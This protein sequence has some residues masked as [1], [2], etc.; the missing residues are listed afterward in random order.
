[1]GKND[2]P[3]GRVSGA[4][5]QGMFAE[6]GGKFSLSGGQPRM[7]EVEHPVSV[8]G[9]ALVGR[10]DIGQYSY[11]GR[12][13]EIRNCIFGRFCS[14]ARRVCI[15]LAE[16]PL[17][18]LTSHPIAHGQP[19]GF[20]NDPYIMRLMPSA[21]S[22]VKYR[23]SVEVGHDVWIGDGAFVRQG[24]RIGTGAVVAARAVVTRDVPPY[25]I[26]SGLPAR[27]Q[28]Y[29]FSEETIRRLLASKWWTRDLSGIVERGITFSDVEA[30]LSELEREEFPVR[31]IPKTRVSWKGKNAFVEDVSA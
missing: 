4:E 11:I 15:G 3:A 6:A 21:G 18:H 22:P 23:S 31:V 16:H 27:I 10:V 1:M 12:G 30:I 20:E 7:M 14:I 19:T 29:R 24:V 5:L 17:D 26:V 9:A 25:A 8:R 28:R 2:I 13:S